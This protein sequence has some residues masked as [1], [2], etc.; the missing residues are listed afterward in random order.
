MK[1]TSCRCGRRCSVG[2]LQSARS[3]TLVSLQ[4]AASALGG[5]R[6]EAREEA[7]RLMLPCWRSLQPRVPPARLAICSASE[8][9]SAT[10]CWCGVAAPLGGYQGPRAAW[11]GSASWTD[12]EYGLGSMGEYGLG[13]MDDHT[14]N[15]SCR[16]FCAIGDERSC[17]HQSTCECLLEQEWL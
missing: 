11:M 15:L 7:A 14:S 2:G 4:V 5:V 17:Q 6:C 10:A 8:M 12:G 16:G 1:C 3:A 9:E 13:S